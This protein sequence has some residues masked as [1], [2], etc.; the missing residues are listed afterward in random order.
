MS[1]VWSTKEYQGTFAGGEG[2]RRGQTIS[3]ERE[4][5]GLMNPAVG[6][7]ITV[8]GGNAGLPGGSEDKGFS[9][10]SP[11]Y[12]PSGNFHNPEDKGTKNPFDIGK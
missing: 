12:Q 2:P 7:N 11:T 10:T 3:D 9:L 5:K 8:Q 1:N 6:K 4:N